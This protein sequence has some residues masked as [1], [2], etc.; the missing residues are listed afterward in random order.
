MTAPGAARGSRRLSRKAAN[1]DV[2]P[3]CPVSVP[4]RSWE[5]LLTWLFWWLLEGLLEPIRPM[6][7]ER[8]KE[9]TRDSLC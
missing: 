8:V 5:E 3:L 7:R 4:V 9:D 2:V 1:T 6:E